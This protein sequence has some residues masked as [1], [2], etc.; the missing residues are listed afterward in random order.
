MLLSFVRG[1]NVYPWDGST[2]GLGGSSYYW[3]T[4]AYPNAS[5]AYYQYFNKANVY[6]SVSYNLALGFSV[7]CLVL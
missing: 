3:A 1:G 6:P 2:R 7:R 4:T 5:Y